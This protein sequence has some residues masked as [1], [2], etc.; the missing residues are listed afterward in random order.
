[1]PPLPKDY[2]SKAVSKEYYRPSPLLSRPP[3]L[4]PL[5]KRR[6]RFAVN[7]YEV[8]KRIP[9]VLQQGV[10]LCYRCKE[11]IVRFQA[12]GDELR[13]WF[14]EHCEIMLCRKCQK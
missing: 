11:A 4:C 5:C 12:I 10:G 7:G 8:G 14:C 1:M 2:A 13:P 3:M 9:S 6:G